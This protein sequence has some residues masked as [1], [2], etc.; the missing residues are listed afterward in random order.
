MAREQKTYPNPMDTDPMVDF[1][2]ER[3]QFMDPAKRYSVPINVNGYEFQA[4]FGE[5]NRLPK[6]VVD[7]LKNARS[8]MSPLKGGMSTP[9][10]VDTAQGGQGRPQSQIMESNMHDQYI[11][12]YNVVEEREL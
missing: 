10:S 3:Q 5:R 7:V 4:V 11:P 2:L 9:H 12:D 1:Y 8:R 6:S